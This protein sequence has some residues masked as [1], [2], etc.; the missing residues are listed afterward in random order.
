MTISPDTEKALVEALRAFLAYDRN[1]DSG[2]AAAVRMML[3]YADAVSKAESALAL[4]AAETA[5]KKEDER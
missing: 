2:H 4:Y 1:D 3:D 5:N